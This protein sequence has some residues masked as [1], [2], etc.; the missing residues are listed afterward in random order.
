MNRAGKL[1]VVVADDH[2]LIREAVRGY[3]AA[4]APEVEIREA[5]CYQQ[6][7]ALC[8]DQ[9]APKPHIILLDLEMPG[10]DTQDR[11]AGLRRICAALPDTAVVVFSADAKSASISTALKSGAQGY[12]PKTTNGA[13]LISALKL[14]LD[15]E[16]YVPPEIMVGGG[17]EAIEPVPGGASRVDL[18]ER[19]S[20]AL[21]LLIQGLTNK[22]I[23]LQLGLQEVTIKMHLR[24]AYR[25][26]GAA[27]R[28]EAVRIAVER[29]LG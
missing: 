4:L 18:T 14:V 22:E 15:G 17:L 13:S 12:I 8:Q 23:G 10:R 9:D 19:E 26:L 16:V 11:W 29:G 20:S 6:V 7:L 1:R 3:L 27:N 21:R 5:A 2:Q 25:K 28:I 24:N